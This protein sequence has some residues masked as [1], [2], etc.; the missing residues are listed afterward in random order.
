MVNMNPFTPRHGTDN[1]SAKLTP[2]DIRI[3]RILYGSGQMSQGKLARQY[4]V[5]Q[6]AIN[7]I[8][9]RKTW[10]SVA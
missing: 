3:I 1:P 8:C 4:K 10:Q 7:S 5:S 2:E 9:L 6:A